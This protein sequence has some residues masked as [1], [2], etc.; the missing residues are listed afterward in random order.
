MRLSR[1]DDLPCHQGLTPIH[2]PATSDSHYNDGYY[3]AFYGPQPFFF[4]GLRLHPNSNVI[5]GY[6]GAVHAGEQRNVRFSRALR[7]RC[8]ELAAGPL[9]LEIAEPMRVQRLV[10]QDNET[11]VS[12]DVAF[13]AVAPP[14]L[15]TG[16]VQYRFGRLLNHVVRYVQVC[17][18][19]GAAAVD[20]RSFAVESWPAVRD[21]SWGIRSS[22]GPHVPIRGVEPEE[23][24]R[25]P[26]ALR[27][28]V[29][30]ALEDHA[31]FFH[32]HDDAEGNR[33]D[34]EGAIWEGGRELALAG[35]RHEL[36][37]HE[38]TRRLRSG[39]FALVDA[40]GREREY[41]FEVAG[42]PAHPQGFGYARG[43]SDEG[44]PG[45]YRGAE[46]REA[47]RFCV[48]DP[49]ALAGPA[50]VPPERRLGGTEYPALLAGPGGSR[51]T[52]HVEHMLY[53]QP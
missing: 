18:A 34:F 22:M 29:P 35:A 20:G 2:I 14:F 9:T 27:L 36:R 1:F 40:E 6:A 25:D 51:G 11:G 47:D 33:L 37:Y 13:E 8:D 26:R 44:Q 53:G 28:W 48:A 15:E 3:F 19:T 39:T 16:H 12:F 45:V 5:D 7:P 49:A 46:V 38:G 32:L 17:R 31:G 30:F 23:S 4:C 10:L 24:D 43:W 42:D 50:H 52:A 41:A 21:H